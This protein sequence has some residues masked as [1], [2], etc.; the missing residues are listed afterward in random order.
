MKTLKLEMMQYFPRSGLTGL[1]SRQ[2]LL[3]LKSKHV[4]TLKRLVKLD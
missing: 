1:Y 3:S 4:S 2:Y